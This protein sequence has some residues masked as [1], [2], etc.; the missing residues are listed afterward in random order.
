M[1]EGYNVRRNFNIGEK[2]SPFL[3]ILHKALDTLKIRKA[4]NHLI[5]W[6]CLSYHPS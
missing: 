1:E 2:P 5:Y 4:K 6:S 3:L